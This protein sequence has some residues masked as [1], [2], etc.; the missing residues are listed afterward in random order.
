MT[1]SFPPHTHLTYKSRNADI[2]SV[3]DPHDGR[4]DLVNETL[5]HPQLQQRVREWPSRHVDE[6][7]STQRLQQ[8]LHWAK[9]VSMSLVLVDPIGNVYTYLSQYNCWHI[10]K[11]STFLH[12]AIFLIRL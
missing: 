2:L 1:A 6:T 12:D 11:L 3:V 7:A 8:F 5:R 9:G 10:N 4:D